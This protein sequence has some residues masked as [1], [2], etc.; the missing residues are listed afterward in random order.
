MVNLVGC[1][2]LNTLYTVCIRPLH[3][4]A[5]PILTAGH[6]FNLWAQYLL[7]IVFVGPC[8]IFYMVTFGDLYYNIMYT[9][10][11]MYY[12]YYYYYYDLLAFHKIII[13]LKDDKT[14]RFYN[15]SLH[16]RYSINTYIII[17]QTRM[18]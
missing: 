5:C 12:Y 8:L 11:C 4:L 2:I 15:Q 14:T 16:K 3:G 1:N 18:L 9:H 6:H 7:C 13:L 10:T 17:I